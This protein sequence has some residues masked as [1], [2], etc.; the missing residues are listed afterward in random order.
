ME[1]VSF[2][3][4]NKVELCYNDLKKSKLAIIYKV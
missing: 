3:C 1:C 2:F 4:A